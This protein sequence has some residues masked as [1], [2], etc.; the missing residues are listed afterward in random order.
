MARSENQ[1]LKLLYLKDYLTRCS[2]P[3][4]PLTITD[5][6]Q[7]LEKY[8][9]SA[10]RKSLYS[11]IRTLQDYG[12]DIVC[13]KGHKSGYYLASRDFELPELRLLVDAVQSSR[14]L[15]E[16]KSTALIRKLANLASRH[17]AGTLSH[18]VVVSG[19]VKTMD[20][21]IY[22]A[23]DAI[24]EAINRNSCIDFHYTEWA[25]DKKRHKRGEMR[26]A[27]PWALV[28]HE[29]NYYLIAYTHEHG[30]THYRV[31]KMQD[32]RANGKKREIVQALREL[33]LAQY[34]KKVFSMY[35]GETTMVKMRF[36]NSLVGVVL[37]RFGTD[38]MLI[39]DGPEHFLLTT[40]IAVSPLFFAWIIG[41]GQRAKVIW[42]EDVAR[43][44]C[45]LCREAL[46]QYDD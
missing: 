10:E 23:V 42:P 8:N 31:D 11:D 4:H 18:Q 33:D 37:D 44:C 35:N 45:K 15:T 13:V 25:L 38:V 43:E 14:F 32:I 19:R 40:Q 2:D 46:A 16:K 26:T 36:H 39:P 5:I 30:I 6:I 20:E 7:H 17:E 28:W 29:E 22:Y 3:E 41:F 1:K 21:S 34:S 12:M 27:T 9:I 24:Q